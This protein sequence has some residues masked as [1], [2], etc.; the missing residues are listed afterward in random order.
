MSVSFFPR[1]FLSAAATA[2]SL[3]TA[4]VY[5]TNIRAVSG[6]WASC[7]GKVGGFV[8][9][10]IVTSQVS[11]IEMGSIF[12][13]VA[14]TAAAAVYCL[15][16]TAG[17]TLGAVVEEVSC[18]SE[19]FRKSVSRRA[20]MVGKSMRKRSTSDSSSVGVGGSTGSGA[21]RCHSAEQPLF[22]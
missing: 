18:Y 8:A 13:A 7:M 12:C 10:F 17:K 3:A 22:K 6:S 21:V 16:E 14:W 20:S 15:P 9:P 1:L 11:Y 2:I 5:S 19:A 4:E